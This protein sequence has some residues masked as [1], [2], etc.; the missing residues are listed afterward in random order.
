MNKKIT[1][2]LAAFFAVFYVKA[3]N[4]TSYF[5]GNPTDVETNPT[6]GSVLMGGSGENDPAMTWFLNRADGGDVL[7]LRASGAD[8]YNDYLFSELGVTV[9]SVETIVFND[10]SAATEPYVLD[11]ISKAE[12]IWFAGGNQ[13]NYISYWRDTEVATLINE[14]VNTRGAVIGGI[15]A[16]MAIMGSMYFSAENGTV[17]STQ[18]LNNPYHPNVTIGNEPFLE[19]DYLKDVITDTHYDDPDRKGRHLVFL[20]HALEMGA[21]TAFGIAC[22]EFTAVCIDPDGLARIYGEFPSFDD[23]AYFIQSNC[24]FDGDSPEVMSPGVPLTWDWTGE[25]VFAYQVKG[26]ESG[27]NTF[28][29]SDWQTA[30]GGAW[31]AWSAVAGEFIE[32]D[33]SNPACAPLSTEEFDPLAVRLYPNPVAD[34]LNIEWA[35]QPLQQIKVYDLRG[36]ELAVYETAAL[37]RLQLDTSN[38]A[39]G[40]YF[41]RLTDAAGLQLTQRFIKN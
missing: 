13:W 9:N 23:N 22:D 11:K 14:A 41:V 36:I 7:V 1:L 8:G 32:V 34:V 38:L 29:L 25:A 27:E 17:T 12:A 37:D 30:S 6:G 28:D 3:Q 39:S 26:T 18:A 15:S 4:Y 16:G 10:A 33:V 5:T 2:C 35:N 31:K 19:V 21:P 40:I 20:A 24:N